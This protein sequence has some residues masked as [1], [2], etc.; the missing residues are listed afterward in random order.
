MA[1]AAPGNDPTP[2][3][4]GLLAAI[5]D[6]ALTV[7]A[8]LQ[9]RLE[10]LATELDEERLRVRQFL[11]HAAAIVCCFGLA[12]VLAIVFVVA[13]AW[14]RFGILAVGVLGLV[15]L[16]I[17]TGLALSLRAKARSRPRFLAATLGEL[18]KDRDRLT[19]RP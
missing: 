5:R 10:I 1:D 14:D 12:I 2:P 17:G 4:G 3:A 11:W 15:F 7:V 6:L 13:L 18:G 16:A 8:L 19:P 9:T